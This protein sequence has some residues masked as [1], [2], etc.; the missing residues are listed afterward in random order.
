MQ[1]KD[2]IRE[3]KKQLFSLETQQGNWNEFESGV[4]VSSKEMIW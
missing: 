1:E 4:Q 3:G 2:R